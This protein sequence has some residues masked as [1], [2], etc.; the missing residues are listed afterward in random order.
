[1]ATKAKDQTQEQEQEQ[2]PAENGE[3]ASTRKIANQPEYAG[4]DFDLEALDELP[5]SEPTGRSRL[6]FDLLT[7]V[8][9]GETPLKWH[10]IA[11][12][13]TPTGAKQVASTINKQVAGTLKKEED[14]RE[15]PAYD[16]YHWQFAAR[17]VAATVTVTNEETGEKETQPHP[18]P[19]A[20]DSVLFA[21]LVEGEAPSEPYAA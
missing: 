16:G 4:R 6:Y 3:Q 14:A 1:M 10:R 12:F 15:L 5:E 20:R 17:K 13:H 18:D 11:T 19:H 8:A 21:R 9:E 7:R 2:A